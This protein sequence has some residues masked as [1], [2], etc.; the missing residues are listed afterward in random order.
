M[1]ITSLGI[2]GSATAELQLQL[3]RK[4]NGEDRW[5]YT[6]PVWRSDGRFEED[7][8]CFC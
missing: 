1:L 5:R 6:Y 4:S 7:E 3:S 2:P 8:A